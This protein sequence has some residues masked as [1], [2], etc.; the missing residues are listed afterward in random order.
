MLCLASIFGAHDSLDRGRGESD[1][2]AAQPGLGGGQLV[3][4]RKHTHISR[5][6]QRV[7]ELRGARR[8]TGERIEGSGGIRR[9]ER[10]LKYDWIR[11]RELNA[12]AVIGMVRGN[13]I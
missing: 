6:Y 9:I 13:L 2:G 10:H 11:G 8:P 4:I 3:F 5:R 7:Q 12:L 1:Q